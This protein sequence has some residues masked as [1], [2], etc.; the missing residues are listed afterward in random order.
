MLTSKQTACFYLTTYQI[1][2]CIVEA[3]WRSFKYITESVYKAVHNISSCLRWTEGRHS[4][5][6]F[7]AGILDEIPISEEYSD[8][9]VL[10]SEQ[11]VDTLDDEL[12]I[13]S[14]SKSLSIEEKFE[15]TKWVIRGRKSKEDR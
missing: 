2:T 8:L 15:D 1:S 13:D 4:E 3:H 12:R 6:L 9:R 14:F 7:W 5:E 10:F 11:S